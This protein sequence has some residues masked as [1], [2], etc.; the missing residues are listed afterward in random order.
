MKQQLLTAASMLLALT[1]NTAC[2]TDKTAGD[3]VDDSWIHTKVKSALVGH[4]SSD[5][6]VE[7]YHGVVQLAGFL[8][9]ADHKASAVK[10]AQGVEGVKSVS[11]QLHVVEGGRSTGR[12]LDDNTLGTKAK[13]ALVDDSM[14]SINVEVNRGVVLL[15]GF[16][17]N[18]EVRSKAVKL[19]EGVTGV[20]KVI[21]GLGIKA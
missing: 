14:A 19:V 10:A 15:S 18:D 2:A 6:N 20:E 13:A 8:T 7:V 16:V 21:N 11:D 3:K 4:G 17:A 9:D 12:T 1:L 5:I